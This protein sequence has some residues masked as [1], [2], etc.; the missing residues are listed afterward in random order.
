MKKYKSILIAITLQTIGTA[1]YAECPNALPTE[2]L[3]D[4]IVVE[5]SGE[6]YDVKK[7][8]AEW[9]ENHKNENTSKVIQE[10]KNFWM[11]PL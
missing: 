4:C 5:D 6:T 8:L 10:K 3:M 1:A 7:N 11:K 2:L 9:Q